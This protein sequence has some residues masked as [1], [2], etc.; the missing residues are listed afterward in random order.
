MTYYQ[1]FD[2]Y[3]LFAWLLDIVQRTES[4]CLAVLSLRLARSKVFEGVNKRLKITLSKR[5]DLAV[6]TEVCRSFVGSLIVGK[7]AREEER[8]N[9]EVLEMVIADVRKL[10]VR[11]LGDIYDAEHRFLEGQREMAQEASDPDLVVAL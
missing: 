10:F 1:W 3:L 7:S 6:P 4:H 9:E 11:G 5:D 8:A 2:L